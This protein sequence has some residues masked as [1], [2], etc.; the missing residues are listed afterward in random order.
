ML[1]LDGGARMKRQLQGMDGLLARSCS[2]EC[3]EERG[4]GAGGP[5]NDAVPFELPSSK[6]SR[7]YGQSDGP[8]DSAT[9]AFHLELL[10]SIAQAPTSVFDNGD[11]W[12]SFDWQT[13]GG[14]QP[15]VGDAGLHSDGIPPVDAVSSSNGS[16]LPRVQGETGPEATGNIVCSNV[17]DGD[18]ETIVSRDQQVPSCPDSPRRGVNTPNPA[19][20]LLFAQRLLRENLA[21]RRQLHDQGQDAHRL[22]RALE[23]RP[24]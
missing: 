14:S 6:R 5:E 15:S 23:V 17:C 8:P 7:E 10:K 9:N 20:L 24:L 19:S 18:V 3:V 21:L 12:K 13:S 16:L 11:F 1:S 4:Y 22:Q 2:E